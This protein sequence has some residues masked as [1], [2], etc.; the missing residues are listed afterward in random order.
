MSANY[1]VDLGNT[2]VSLGSQIGGS[3]FPGSGANIGNICDMINA[4]TFTN[5]VVGTI[6]QFTSGQLR[7]LVQTSDT[8]NSG[9]FTDPTSGL[10]AFPTVFTSGGMATLNSGGGANGGTFGLG[11]S[12]QF[13]QSGVIVFAGF[14]R[15]HRYVRSLAL[16]GDIG[17]W[18]SSVGFVAQLKTTGSGGGYTP[19]PTSGP[20]NV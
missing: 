18:D 9:D 11:V 13:V 1:V 10:A 4:N 2:T 12:G 19:S 3:L 14:Q 8:T 16:S 6:S 7:L 5:L 20:V 15:P 17:R